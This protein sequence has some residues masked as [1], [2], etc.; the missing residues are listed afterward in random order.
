V[1]KLVVVT[2]ILAVAAVAMISGSGTGRLAAQATPST[3]HKIALIDMAHVFKN[4]AKF[5]SLRE[6]LKTEIKASEEKMQADIQQLQAMKEKLQMMTETS[7]GFAQA[8]AELAS[9]AAEIDAGRKVMQRDFLRKES[10]IYKQVYMEVTSAVKMYADYYKYSLV[11]RFNRQQIQEDDAPQAVING[12][13]KQVVYH[14]AED[15]ITDAVL[16]YLNKK[17]QK[18]SASAGAPGGANRQ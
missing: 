13:N 7:P 15:D 14:R 12:M 4:Y 6:T 18:E 8:E 9:K 11:L 17:Y 2:T 10:Q 16:D 3:P 5:E 1:K